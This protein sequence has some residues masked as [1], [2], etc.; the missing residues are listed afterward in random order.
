MA[1]ST[2]RTRRDGEGTS[3]NAAKNASSPSPRTA[4]V[5]KS[6]IVGRVLGVLGLT[7]ARFGRARR[8]PEFSALTKAAGDR[9]LGSG[10]APWLFAR[11]KLRT[12]PV[13]RPSSS[14]R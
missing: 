8:D 4:I 11:A 13:T 12:D 2:A 7:F 1:A 6:L 14:S 3:Y 5:V 9:Y 10:V